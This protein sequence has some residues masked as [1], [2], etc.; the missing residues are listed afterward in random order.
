M[1]SVRVGDGIST[2]GGWHQYVWGMASVR[3]GD[4]ISTYGGWHQYVWG[5]ASVRVGDGI[6]TCGDNISTVGITSV[7]WG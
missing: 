1:A 3:V 4:G 2:C 5:M 7:L 6:S